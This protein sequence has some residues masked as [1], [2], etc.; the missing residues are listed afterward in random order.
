[1]LTET[2]ELLKTHPKKNK[3][4]FLPL[5]EG[6]A[7]ASQRFPRHLGLLVVKSKE[8][9]ISSMHMFNSS[10]SSSILMVI[11]KKNLKMTPTEPF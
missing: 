3:K 4:T 11:I 2:L 5:N 10:S 9:C 7:S 6:S 8:N 1:M